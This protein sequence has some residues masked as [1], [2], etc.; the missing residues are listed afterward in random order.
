MN[1]DTQKMNPD[2][3]KGTGNGDG[4]SF[5]TGG[6]ATGTGTVFTP[7]DRQR[8]RGQFSHRRGQATGD[9]QRGRGQ[10]SH[11]VP[12]TIRGGTGNGDGDSFHTEYREQ[13]EGTLG[14][15]SY[16][17]LGVTSKMSLLR[18]PCDFLG[19]LCT[20]VERARRGQVS[21]AIHCDSESAPLT[22]AASLFPAISG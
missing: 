9:R 7:G 21:L 12:G 18:K 3:Q 16:G 10:F 6:Q 19:K 1:P 15:T 13:S 20:D 17:Q 22:Q 5:H 11:R 4:D 8:G 14:V 2:T